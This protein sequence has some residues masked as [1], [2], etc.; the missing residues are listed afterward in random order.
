MNASDR[1]DALDVALFDG[2]ESQ[3]DIPERRSLL[4]L[5]RAVARGNARYA[6]LEIGSHLG[7]S[8]QTHLLDPRCVRIY[9]IDPRP[10][11][12]ADDR[13]PGFVARYEGNSTSRMMGL[14]RSLAP[15][16]ADKVACFEM[17]ASEVDPRQLSEPPRL[18]FIDGEHTAAAVAA[19]F[20]FCLRAMRDGGI[21]AFHDLDYVYPAVLR[22]CRELRRSRPSV[23]PL[24]MEGSVFAIFLDPALADGDD[25]LTRLRR[26]HRAIML[27]LGIRRFMERLLPQPLFRLLTGWAHRLWGHRE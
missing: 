6:Y 19:D 25:Y 13:D 18:A 26:R 3:T 9:S 22:I 15:A 21:V 16:E 1:V 14:L 17:R 5:Q 8:L 2:I 12:Q 11:Q 24:K 27:R 4:A 23:L 7:G 10:G 20:D